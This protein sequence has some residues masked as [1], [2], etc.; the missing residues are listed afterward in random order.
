MAK[1]FWDWRHKLLS[2]GLGAASALVAL[3][4]TLGSHQTGHGPYEAI[5]AA[6]PA[7]VGAVIATA[8]VAVNERHAA[9]M[10]A[11]YKI[12]AH[13]EEGLFARLTPEMQTA[14]APFHV[15]TRPH[16]NPAA[17]A[18]AADPVVR[19]DV[20]AGSDAPAKAP[21]NSL[22]HVRGQLGFASFT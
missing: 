13:L 15:L 22:S 10:R 8:V 6:T 12:G 16:F 2:L 18:G 4:A 21:G 17:E 11:T 9:I 7:L 3:S 1:V 5:A 19:L 14:E 20:T